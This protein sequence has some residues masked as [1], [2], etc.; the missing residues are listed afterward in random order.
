MLAFLFTAAISD[1]HAG[2]RKADKLL[3]QGQAAEDQQ[4]FDRAAALY[5]RALSADPSDPAYRLAVN[6]VRLE[7]ARL[8]LQKGRDL[9]RNGHLDEAIAE[10]ERAFSLDPSTGVTLQEIAQTKEMIEAIRNGESKSG[11]AQREYDSRLSLLQGPPQLNPVAH[12]VAPLKIV[13]QPRI[14]Y[15]TICKLAG[16]D[17]LFDP[18]M[19]PTAK[20][21]TLELSQSTSGERALD[22]VALLT[23]TYWKI[24][25]AN[26]IFVTDD[27]PTK[28]RDYEDQ[29]VKVLFLQHTATLQEFQ[30]I[31][32][33]IRQATDIRHI[34]PYS[35]QYAVLVR[36]TP[37]QVTLA[38]RLF[39]DID[40]PKAEVV[41]E[42]AILSANSDYTRSLTAGLIS[43]GTGA[44][45][46]NLAIQPTPSGSA[47][48]PVPLSNLGKINFK[49]YAT[50]LPNVL[51][52]AVMSDNRTKVLQTPQIRASDG[53][54]ATLKIGR[55]Y[56]FA[57]G[58]FQQGL[59][60]TGVNP[61]VSTQFQFADLGVNLDVTPH[62]HGST[63]EIT[64]HVVVDL[65]SLD[66]TIDVGGGLTQPVIGQQKNEADIRVHD[67]ETSLLGGLISST[68]VSTVSGI[69]GLVNVPVLG[70][71]FFG[72]AD[73][74]K[75][76]QELMIVLIPHIVSAPG[77]SPA[78]LRG[79]AIGP[80]PAIRIIY[81]DRQP[82]TSP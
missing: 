52:H 55:R 6:R 64:M 66:S 27:N 16:L 56:P 42:F 71:A 49:D 57:T 47:A 38:E 46:L 15:E 19:S 53:A 33:A 32:N 37:D 2:T 76:R 14:L 36:G 82:P 59:G 61:L 80:E 10:L 25:N 5:E 40:R 68:G 65:T 41:M 48:G 28:R 35:A 51:L 17:V 39:R 58:S 44:T 81:P 63:G 21:F 60:A 29:V 74:E 45:G 24:V 12:F 34:V 77:P 13:N 22:D 3:K 8:H 75:H 4:D 70:R 67:G 7:A 62:V 18:Q 50:T 78:D 23:H 69:P 73:K 54:K 26:T 9:R 30:E 20:G 43:A 31:V 11:E 72:S 1:V 79:I